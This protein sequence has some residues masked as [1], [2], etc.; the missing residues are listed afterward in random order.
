MRT[1]RASGA[2][3][4]RRGRYCQGVVDEYSDIG[5]IIKLLPPPVEPPADL[6]DR[7]IATMAAALAGN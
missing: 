7:T 4:A 2:G 1:A 6:E 5:P 3:A